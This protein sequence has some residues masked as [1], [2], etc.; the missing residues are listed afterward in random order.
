VDLPVRR[1][2]R[3]RV[4][5]HSPAGLC[6]FAATASK[7]RAAGDPLQSHSVH[8]NRNLCAHRLSFEKWTKVPRSA[9]PKPL[10][11]LVDAR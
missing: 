4:D 3:L 10:R 8:G 5:W 1:R 6:R 2:L 7:L 11:C 9:A